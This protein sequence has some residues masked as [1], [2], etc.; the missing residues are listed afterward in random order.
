MTLRPARLVILITALLLAEG[1]VL[2][3]HS[4][5]EKAHSREIETIAFGALP[6]SI[7]QVYVARDRGLFAAN[8]IRMNVTEYATGV[9]AI[10]ALLK[11]DAQ[12]VWTAEFPLVRAALAGKEFSVIAGSGR[13]DG[14]YL[15][16]RKGR[17]I[18]SISDLPGRFL[19]LNGLSIQDVSLVDV[20]PRQAMEAL[21]NNKVDAV[22]TGAPDSVGI[23]LK[24]A[25]KIVSWSVQSGQQ[26]Y[27]LF[28]A[29]KDWM[30]R[31]PE[32]LSRFL[33]SLAQADEYMDHHPEESRRIVQQW[34]HCDDAYM[35]KFWSE[36]YPSLSLDQ[37]L[38][39]AMEDEARWMIKNRLTKGKTVPDFAD[40][41]YADAL[42]AV[43]PE[44]VKIT[45]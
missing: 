21:T 27:G 17:G 12:I 22:V 24:L 25:G 40:Y 37:S 41:V 28:T 9:T 32:V 35:E 38:F 26:G 4:F 5:S 13:F 2:G 34:M 31:H 15:F 7:W 8:N 36:C 44:A 20:P 16:A 45:R 30:R 43:K 1:I 10:N 3:I 23:R 14:E 19:E 29:R 42:R 6:G 18:K 11:G 33:T 39:T